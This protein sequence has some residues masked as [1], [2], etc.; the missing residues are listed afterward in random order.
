MMDDLCKVIVYVIVITVS[1]LVFIFDVSNGSSVGN[2][3]DDLQG[4]QAALLFNILICFSGFIP[5]MCQKNQTDAATEAIDY[6][7]YTVAELEREPP[8]RPPPI[9]LADPIR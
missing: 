2:C 7:E 3:A 1:I 4:Y 8:R 5:L 6:L 9:F